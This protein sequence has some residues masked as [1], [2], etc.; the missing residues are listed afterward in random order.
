MIAATKA[1]DLLRECT[2]LAFKPRTRLNTH[3]WAKE[4]VRL[5]ARF[6]HRPGWYDVDFTPYMRGPHEWFSD[7]YVM[8]ITGA[9]CRQI[10][11]T[12]WLA[13]CM[14][15]GVVEDPGPGMYVT[16]TSNNAQ[17]FSEREWLPRLDLC[18]AMA[19]LMPDNRDGIKVLEQH[20]KTCTMRF[21]GS[22]SPANLMSRPIR[23]LYA[24][25]VDTWPQGND[26][27]AP[28]LETAEACTLSYGSAKKILRVS[29]PTIPTGAIWQK[30]LA[31]TQH[32]YFVPCPACDQRTE[33]LFDQ[34]N[35][36]RDVC[37]DASG[38]W[39]LDVLR[40]TTT[41]VCPHCKV[42]QAQNMQ[43]S[44]VLQGEWRQ[45]NPK[46]TKRHISW[47]ISAL[48]SSTVSWGDIAVMFIQKKD[49]PG[50]LHDFHNHYL[51]LPFQRE[52]ASVTVQDVEK[53]VARSPEYLLY[54]TKNAKYRLPTQLRA[55]LMAVDVQ[56]DGFWWA[57][58]GMAADQSTYLLDY[59][60]ASSW[61]DLKDLLDRTYVQPDGTGIQTLKMLV[62]CGY[63]AKRQSGVYDFALANA[64]RIWPCQGR[65]SVHG[66]L[67]PVRLAQFEHRGMMIDGI[68]LRDDIYKEQLYI[69]TLKEQKSSWFLA[70]NICSRYKKQLSDERLVVK[71]NERGDE[72][73][74]WVSTKNNH[75]GDVEKYLMAGFDII[76]PL[77]DELDPETSSMEIG[78]D[79]EEELEEGGHEVVGAS[80]WGSTWGGH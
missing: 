14:S 47:H 3:E 35:F 40:E 2:K 72:E 54:N 66:L 55:I 71:L 53:M 49:T 27:D 8:E 23:Y 67:Q 6:T 41:W 18:P 13:N 70:R 75:L 30:F 12:T 64:G 10:G 43:S 78:G 22:N 26:D 57:Q 46:A 65:S 69:S 25:E 33:L 4:N 11:G 5:D 29:T 63:R 9:K 17:S 31:G 39:N 45:T 24:D 42:E 51:G 52:A 28:A 7:P 19:E 37:R 16:S 44:M 48:Y 1:A 59:G 74:V 76:I 80:P 50:G 77:L 32:K 58:R 20:F 62:D 21:A 15:Y 61:A 79:T 73:M 38:H 60:A 34:L 36:H 56:Q 68:Q